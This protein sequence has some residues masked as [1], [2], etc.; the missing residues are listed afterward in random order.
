MILAAALALLIVNLWTIWRF[1]DDKHRAMLGHRRVPEANLLALAF[2]GGTP[3]A[4]LARAWFR[5]KTRKQPFSTWLWLIATVQAGALI[6]LAW[7][8]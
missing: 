8:R 5:H 6:A 3:G 7:S 4:F 2:A 1:H